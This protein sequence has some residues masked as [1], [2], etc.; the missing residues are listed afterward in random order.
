MPCMRSNSP[1]KARLV[2]FGYKHIISWPSSLVEEKENKFLD[3][4]H[5]LSGVH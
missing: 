4:G 3:L 2:R 5:L 1:V